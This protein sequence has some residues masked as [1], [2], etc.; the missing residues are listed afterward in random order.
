M[1]KVRDPNVNI[2][3]S[4]LAV[5]LLK[6]KIAT[7]DEQARDMAKKIVREGNMY[8]VSNRV[9]IIKPKAAVRKQ[10]ERVASKSEQYANQFNAALVSI[11]GSQAN[12]NL[13]SMEIV[14]PGTRQFILLMEV[15]EIALAF[16]EAF[17]YTI[18]DGFNRFIEIGL[19]LFNRKYS[20]VR[21]KTMREKIFQEQI[22]TR[23]VEN[24]PYKNA[25]VQMAKIYYGKVEDKT[26][27]NRSKEVPERDFLNFVY[28]AK[29]CKELK[30]SVVDWVEAQ[31]YALAYA[32]AMPELYQ[33]HGD[34]AKNRY[35]KYMFEQKSKDVE[36]AAG[37]R[38]LTEEDKEYL[39]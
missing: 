31:F 8:N 9:V 26:G 29:E 3:R 24:N 27:I 30:G 22:T 32:D 34:M 18:G 15:T 17:D 20:L 33:M 35:V 16:C 21:F 36:V 23:D 19:D 1:R 10:L 12:I 28:A 2:K 37:D 6:T 25:T 14:Q 5:V 38:V 7:T 11:R 39:R 4:D 13:S